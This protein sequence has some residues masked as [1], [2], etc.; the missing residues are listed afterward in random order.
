MAAELVE[1]ITKVLT[2][3][4][5]RRIS[6][7]DKSKMES[8]RSMAFHLKKRMEKSIPAASLLGISRM[9][10]NGALFLKLYIREL[11][12]TEVWNPETR[13]WEKEDAVPSVLQREI[14]RITATMRRDGKTEEEI[15]EY[16]E[17]L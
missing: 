15:K 6:C 17:S 5:P 14:D 12:G 1:E 9:E 16:I 4:Q 10:E 3:G 2:D 13:K 7:E 11:A 8:L